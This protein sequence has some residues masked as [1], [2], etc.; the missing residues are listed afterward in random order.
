M[1]ATSKEGEF[2]VALLDR[3]RNM[4]DSDSD[5]SGAPAHVAEDVAIKP[6]RQEEEVVDDLTGEDDLPSDS[7]SSLPSLHLSD[8]TPI[9]K[10]RSYQVEML[11]ESLK[12]N[13]IIAAD[14]GSG[15]THMQVKKLK[16]FLTFLER[17]PQHQLIWFLA[18]T[19][20]LCSQQ[21]E[22]L[23]SQITS[24]Q[25]KCLKGEDGVDRWSSQNE[26]DTVLRNVRIVV[27]TFQVLLDALSHAFIKMESLALIIFDEAHHC[28]GNHPGAKIMRS[29]YHPRKS[30]GSLIPDILGL[31]ASPVMRSDPNS[32][33]KIEQTLDAVARTP[34][35]HSAEL[36]RQVNLPVLQQVY[37][38]SLDPPDVFTRY[39]KSIESLGQVYASLNIAED[40]YIL[41]LI[42]ENTEKSKRELPEV[43]LHHRTKCQRQIKS[44]HATS[45]KICHEMGA[46]G[47]DHYISEVV[48]KCLRVTNENDSFLGTWDLSSTE[49]LYIAKEMKKVRL[50]TISS[51]MSAAVIISDKVAKVIDTI[52]RESQT[53]QGIIFVQTRAEVAILYHILSVHPLIRG[54]FKIGT[55]VGTSAN[56]YRTKN[57]GELIDVIPQKHTLSLFKA[58]VIKLVIATSVLEEGIDVP[59]CNMVVC[60][61]KPAN[62]K[63]FVQRRGRARHRASKLILLLDPK[64]DKVNDWQ[65]L[66]ADMKRLYEDEMRKLTAV[67]EVE[68]AEQGDG[69]YFRVDST[70]ALLD[71]DNAMAHLYHF[72]A[73]LPTKEYVDQRPDFIC[74]REASKLVRCRIILPISVIEPLRRYESRTSWQSENNSMKDAAFEAYVA[75][76]KA[77]LVN[78]NLLPLLRHGGIVDE[79]L[80]SEVEKRAAI[81]KVE[82]QIN[83]W[84]E[85]AKASKTTGS[86]RGYGVTLLQEPLIGVERTESD[87]KF[88]VYLPVE[89]PPVKPFRLYWNAKSEMTVVV[90]SERLSAMPG[91]RIN[92]NALA[93]LEASFG[94]RFQIGS[95][96]LPVQ[97]TADKGTPLQG[98][99]GRQPVHN[100]LQMEIYSSLIRE[101]NE[102][103]IL[104]QYIE[105]L[106]RKPQIEA[107]Q[108]PYDN[109]G[110]F[111]VETPHLSVVRLPRRTDFLHKVASGNTPASAKAYSVVLPA[112][113]CTVDETPFHIVQF[114]RFIPSIIRRLEITFIADRL[115]K[116]LLKEVSISNLDLIVTAISASSAREDSNYQRLEFLGDSILKTCTSVQLVAEYPLWHEGY[117][118]AKKDRLISNSRLSRAAIEAGLDK[119]IVTKAFTGH[120]WRPLYV[121][122]LLK[123]APEVPKRSLSSKVL[124]DVVEA[125]I[126]ASM[127]DGGITKALKCLQ[128]FLPE[129]EWHP[130]NIRQEALFQRVPDVE[131]PPT[132]ELLEGLIGYTFKKKALL[133][134][135]MTHASSTT[136][137]QSLE[138]LEF[139]GDSIL[140]NIVVS[141]M[142]KQEPDLSHFQMHLLRT[143][144]VNADFLA[145]VCM[146]WAVEQERS[147]LVEVSPLRQKGGLASQFQE[148]STTAS[149]PLW[150]FMRHMSPRLGEVQ[151]ATARHHAELRDEINDAIHSGTHYPW[152]LLARLQAPKFYSDIVESLLGAVW[153]DS[154]SLDVCR[155]LVE[156]MGILPYMERILRDEVQIW[157][158][159]EEI[160]VLADAET[161]KYVIGRR[162]VGTP[163]EGEEREER[164]E[165]GY[166]CKVFVGEEEIVE[167]GGGV[168]KEEVKTKAAE[169]AVAVLKARKLDW[170]KVNGMVSNDTLV[171]GDDEMND[172][173][174]S[175]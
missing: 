116:T 66:E 112:S 15:K 133:I 168:S 41:Y 69:R 118:S 100:P 93:I 82:E 130:L 74:F 136:G 111:P 155:G 44:F 92:E 149:I 158:P 57:L 14:T 33:A 18:P 65:Q 21:F 143:V 51:P 36:R 139:L 73:T 119:F 2:A 34:T 27:S 52:V 124:A 85:V 8:G 108:L 165:R 132:L 120:K 20:S 87:S 81:M 110:G 172:V 63:S 164:E 161:V 160:G 40:P 148:V 84:I 35:K 30:E 90:S 9:V 109:Y 153:I 135:S 55:M 32:L 80:R 125:L 60:F 175:M 42:N 174:M 23:Q 121:D 134:E 142:W 144:L 154:G 159:K 58:G 169:R 106:P 31:T 127:V 46:Y 105:W 47:A 49:K 64:T 62:L 166:W 6:Q 89:L 152:A 128:V 173:E 91:S 29:F 75:L 146:E 151:A 99:L 54:R 56:N 103:T 72:C 167:M 4:S 26:W 48:N 170:V 12:H 98:Q 114:G 147:D 17:I 86:T 101:K 140:D 25:I 96:Q 78:D 157:H 138:R 37:Y 122:D 117:L 141:A 16:L 123:A 67:L 71:L 131:L 22:Y 68:D 145:F 5:S 113:H 59:A 162:K 115:S 171:D 83:P 43:L 137:S 38:Q 107:V 61:Q 7:A 53:I 95:K 156:R 45:L 39:T 1:H 126:G 88:C 76:Y 102:G 3:V 70:G 24:V 11:E 13:I 129:V 77:G 50:N 150:R 97:F 79:L 163:A 94:N 10:P 19:V 28:V 104:Y